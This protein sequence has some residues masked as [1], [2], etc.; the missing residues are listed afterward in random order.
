VQW[1]AGRRLR[2][3]RERPSTMKSGNLSGITDWYKWNEPALSQAPKTPGVYVFRMARR[4]TL[5]EVERPIRHNLHRFYGQRAS[6]NQDTPS[7]ASRQKR[8][9]HANLL[10]PR[11]RAKRSWTTRG[12]LGHVRRSTR[13]TGCRKPT[14]ADV[15]G[16][17][18]RAAAFEPL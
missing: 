5:R 16:G 3:L 12:C 2:S 4:R 10:L 11:S 13:G 18:Y 9:F 6:L 8:G 17:P 15:H 1:S 14:S 7:P